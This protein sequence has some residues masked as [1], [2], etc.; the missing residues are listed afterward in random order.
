MSSAR[1]RSH[2]SWRAAEVTTAEESGDHAMP[3][4]WK[5]PGVRL[6]GVLV[7]SAAMT[8]TCF[9]RSKTQS[10]VSRRAKNRSTLARRL[11]GRVGCAIALVPGAAA[12]GDP[13]CVGRPGDIIEAIGHGA[14]R[15]DLARSA[16]RCDPQRRFHGLLPLGGSKGEEPPVGRPSR[17]S[18][19]RPIGEGRV[20]EPYAPYR[21]VALD[22][23][24]RDDERHMFSVG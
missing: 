20:V 11:P 22:V 2:V 14:R 6:R 13:P 15:A 23:S 5:S 3:L 24:G 16:D 21:G 12:E 4:C 17:V 19:D 1:S 10:S 7:P 8:Y 9:G 18:I